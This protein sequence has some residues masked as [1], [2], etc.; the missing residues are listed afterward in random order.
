[1][2]TEEF[3]RIYNESR[4]G[5][6]FFVRHWAVRKFQYS[7]GVQACAECGLQWF[8]DIC[9]TELPQLIRSG[10]M[11]IVHLRVTASVANLSMELADNAPPVWTRSHIHTDCPDGDWYF[12]I[13]NE[14]VRFA[15]I[16]PEE[17]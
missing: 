14:G 6:N 10:D 9:A 2:K 8:L 12:W 17:Y 11:G 3:K 13:A 16:L 7:D 1:M 15:M 4:N 5:C